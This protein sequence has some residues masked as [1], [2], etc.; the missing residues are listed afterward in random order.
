MISLNKELAVTGMINELLLQGDK[1][2][3]ININIMCEYTRLLE[4]RSGYAVLHGFSEKSLNELLMFKPR[5]FEYSYIETDRSGKITYKV[6]GTNRD[7]IRLM[8][9][10]LDELDPAVNYPCDFLESMKVLELLTA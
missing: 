8:Q 5:L 4:A 9:N 3:Y 6:K 1:D 7:R 10:I 2:V